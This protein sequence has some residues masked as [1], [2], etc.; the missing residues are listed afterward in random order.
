[1]VLYYY[2]MQ[3]SPLDKLFQ[4]KNDTLSISMMKK[5]AASDVAAEGSCFK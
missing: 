5:S 4:I 1:M 3:S 2:L